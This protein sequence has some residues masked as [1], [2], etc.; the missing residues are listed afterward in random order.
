MIPTSTRIA[1]LEKDFLRI[2]DVDRPK[3]SELLSQGLAEVKAGTF[4]EPEFDPVQLAID[5]RKAG[6]EGEVARAWLRVAAFRREYETAAPSSGATLT[7]A[8]PTAAAAPE[9]SDDPVAQI[10]PAGRPGM[11]KPGAAPASRAEAIRMQIADLEVEL[12]MVNTRL[13]SVGWSSPPPQ[14]AHV[15][16]EWSIFAGVAEPP[17]RDDGGDELASRVLRAKRD[18]LVDELA[19][20]RASVPGARRPGG[21]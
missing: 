13:Q 20:L 5:A 21:W 11:F 1:V 16:D 7:Y 9:P 2:E 19:R 10:Y 15:S 4:V 3:I 14:R 6:L 18:Q 8:P 17:G 12:R